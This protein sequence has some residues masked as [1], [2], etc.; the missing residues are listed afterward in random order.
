MSAEPEARRKQ[1]VTAGRDA[2]VAG[3]DLIVHVAATGP[4][5]GEN[6][7]GQGTDEATRSGSHVE[8]AMIRWTHQMPPVRTPRRSRPGPSRGPI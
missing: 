8:V 5:L 7:A 2:F 6:N 4:A 3:R 1:K